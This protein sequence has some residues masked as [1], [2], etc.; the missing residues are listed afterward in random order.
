MLVR[1]SA[2]SYIM[3]KISKFS[4]SN[5]STLILM[6][7]AALMVFSPDAKGWTIQQL[8]SLGF[9]QPALDKTPAP[10]SS[11]FSDVAF[12]NGSGEIITLNKLKG[13]VVFINFWVTWCPPCRAEMP[14]INR[15]SQEL[16]GNKDI[17]FL[18]VDVDGDYKN[19]LKFME[20]KK[21]SLPVYTVASDIP[22][23]LLDGSIPTTIIFDKAGRLV[24]RHVGAG[25]FGSKKVKDYLNKLSHE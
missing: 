6:G 18:M 3:F 13:K 19:A 8:M 21:F 7:F 25:N 22:E 17:L 10:P 16:K 23:S 20:R 1:L 15:L 4:F 12:K 24:F 2:I 11:T 9:F 14:S 5:L